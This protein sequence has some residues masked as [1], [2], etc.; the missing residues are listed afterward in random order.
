MNYTRYTCHTHTPTLATIIILTQRREEHNNETRKH[1]Y[2][3]SD[4]T[5]QQQIL[6]NMSY[7]YNWNIQ[8]IL[9]TYLCVSGPTMGFANS[10]TNAFDANIIPTATVSSTR[11]LCR[12]FFSI[13]SG[14]SVVVMLIISEHVCT[15]IR[16]VYYVRTYRDSP[17][18][19][20]SVVDT[21]YQGGAVPRN[22]SCCCCWCW[23]ELL[24][25]QGQLH[26]A[27]TRDGGCAV[28]IVVVVVVVVILLPNFM[29][30]VA[31]GWSMSY[32][33]SGII[34]TRTKHVHCTRVSG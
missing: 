19:A 23:P 30:N 9:H 10:W 6:Y 2:T 8:L 32:R 13:C 22:S 3:V 26:A 34:G 18:G 5:T 31:L 11:S 20:R 33:N 7:I 15:Y 17:V 27:C 1:W 12:I 14:V 28:V 24:F 25:R 29:L 21:L 4:S 16:C